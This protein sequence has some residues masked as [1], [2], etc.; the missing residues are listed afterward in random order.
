MLLVLLLVAGLPVGLL[1]GGGALLREGGVAGAAA[2]L[3]SAA[4]LCAAALGVVAALAVVVDL[5]LGGGASGRLGHLDEVPAPGVARH[6]HDPA[7]PDEA[8]LG[9]LGTVR[10]HPVLVEIEDLLVPASVTE[11]PFGDL[12]EGVVVT[13]LG[14]LDP[15]VLRVVGLG[16]AAPGVGV[17]GGAG[18]LLGEGG[19]SARGLLLLLGEE[20]AAGGLLCGGDGAPLVPLH[21]VPELGQPRGEAGGGGA[22][23][24]EGGDELPGEELAGAGAGNAAGD[25]DAGD[26]GLYLDEHTGG[27]LGPGEPHDDREDVQEGAGGDGLLEPL[28]LRHPVR[29]RPP[30]GHGQRARHSHDQHQ[31]RDERE[32]RLDEVP[33]R[34]PPDPHGLRGP[35]PRGTR[36]ARR[37]SRRA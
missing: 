4:L 3:G 10:L 33:E 9:Q 26:G 32:E 8:G 2:L 37:A 24:Q 28:Q 5:L 7:G 16:R 14:R 36:A 6:L 15:V 17:R 12:P 35:V 13:A 19:G 31:Q 23:E 22:D 34:T 20:A 1:V 30:D 29:Q 18:G 25:A 21:V 27:E 11:V